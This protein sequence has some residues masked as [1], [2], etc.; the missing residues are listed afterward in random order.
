MAW[1][2]YCKILSLVLGGVLA[3]A[4]LWAQ[5]PIVKQ[6]IAAF[7]KEDLGQ[8]QTLIDQATQDE[9]AKTKESTW[10]YRGAIYEQLMRKNIAS[11]TASYYLEQALQAYQQALSL[12]PASSQYHSFAQVNFHGLWA[13]YLDR[14]S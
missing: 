7:D 1:H 3:K 6:A 4:P 12:A 8:A 2:R 10:Y 9:K 13:Y 5:P 11:D 14:G